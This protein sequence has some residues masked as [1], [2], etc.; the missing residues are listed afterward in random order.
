M[1]EYRRIMTV[2]AGV[3]ALAPLTA[4]WPGLDAWLTALLLGTAALAVTGYWM[5]EAI[6]ELRFQLE[7]R[8]LDARDA[9]R[10]AAPRTEVP[11]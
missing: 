4:V 6:R 11:V 5:C 8:A 9:V 3:C 2:V 10:A 7:M 1:T